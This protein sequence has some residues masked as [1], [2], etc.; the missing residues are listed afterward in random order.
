MK[1]EWIGPYSWNF[2][3]QGPYWRKAFPCDPG[4]CHEAKVDYITYSSRFDGRS[5][6]SVRRPLPYCCYKTCWVLYNYHG[7]LPPPHHHIIFFFASRFAT[8]EG[9]EAQQSPPHSLHIG[10]CKDLERLIAVHIYWCKPPLNGE[11]Q[12]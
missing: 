1:A 7:S 4:A 6:C 2:P 5:L 9:V 8:F 11:Y 3:F 10:Q 12:H